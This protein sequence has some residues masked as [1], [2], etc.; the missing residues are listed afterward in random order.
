MYWEALTPVLVLL[1]CGEVGG[2]PVGQLRPAE[3]PSAVCGIRPELRNGTV[4]LR[5]TFREERINGCDI[6]KLSA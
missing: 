5:V 4:V 1:C 6:R 3:W 2:Q